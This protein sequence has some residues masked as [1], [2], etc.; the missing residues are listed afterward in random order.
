MF[1]RLK[2][3]SMLASE[4]LNE[5]IRTVG[6]PK[7]LVS[8]GARAEIYRRFGAVAKEYYRIKQQVT[9]P[10]S[11]GSQSRAEAAIMEIKQGI[12]R[13]TQR[14]K[15]PNRLWDYGGKWVAAIRRLTAHDIPSLH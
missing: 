8:D 10:Y 13:A 12:R 9:E 14:S 11:G 4:A 7:E 5:V 15:L 1:Y 6:V 3:E 2:K